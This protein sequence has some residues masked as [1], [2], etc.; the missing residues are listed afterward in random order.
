MI[1]ALAIG[2]SGLAAYFLREYLLD[3]PPVRSVHLFGVVIY[4]GAVLIGFAL[5]IGVYR[6]SFRTDVL[7]QY[8][9][10]M[11]A[12]FFS[13]P[14]VVS[15]FY[16]LKWHQLPRIFTILFFISVPVVYGL[17]R[18]LLRKF[19]LVMR[20]RGFGLERTL[21][22]DQGEGGPF[23]FRRYD[24]MPELGYSIVGVALWN[25]TPIKKQNYSSI[26]VTHCDT[27]EDLKRVVQKKSIDRVVITTVDMRAERLTEIIQASRES[28]AKLTVLSQES[29]ELLRF[30]HVKDLAGIT[31]YSMPRK[32][33]EKTK[34]AVKR[35]FDIFGSLLAILVL[36]PIIIL[37]CLAIFIEDGRPIFYKQRRALARG[38]REFGI[39]KIRTMVKHAE[40][41]QAKM[42]QNNLRSGGLFLMKDDPRI[43]K[44]G[45]IIRKFSIDELPQ[46]INVLKGEMSLV[47]PRPL[48]IADLENIAPQNRFDGYYALRANAVPGMTGLWQICGRREVSFKE[49]VLLDLYYI[50]NQSLMFDL[51]IIFA[52]IPVV[53][54]GKGAY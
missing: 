36:S 46:V 39:L 32:K 12:Y 4:S 28:G 27:E 47:G 53:L 8:T 9:L 3:L 43:L 54:F 26:E 7:I 22:I 25:G 48:P 5:I 45:R 16:F 20:N 23:I 2:I 24:L 51:E 49:M 38:Q 10:A 34:R 11:R 15:S 30:S 37:A 13:V 18:V 29:E 42:Y 21:L 52:T 31:L 1:D 19:E 17:G 33:I 44:T 6:A 14:V 50:D 35:A 40:I 41:E